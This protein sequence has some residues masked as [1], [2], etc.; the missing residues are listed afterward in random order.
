MDRR[1]TMP[2][3]DQTLAQFLIPP[4]W[5]KRLLR[6]CKQ[7][8]LLVFLSC[9]VDAKLRSLTPVKRIPMKAFPGIFAAS[10]LIAAV[11]MTSLPAQEAGGASITMAGGGATFASFSGSLSFAGAGA[12]SLTI[13]SYNY[14]TNPVRISTLTNYA[15]VLPQSLYPALF[16]S[17]TTISGGTLSS[18]GT[19]TTGGTIGL[20]LG[21]TLSVLPYGGTLSLGSTSLGT[22]TLTGANTYTG[23]TTISAGTLQIGNGNIGSLSSGGAVVLSSSGTLALNL[24]SGATFGTTVLSGTSPIIGGTG[25]LTLGGSLPYTGAT[26][27]NGGSLTLNLNGE[28]Y[29][30]GATTAVTVGTLEIG[31]GATISA[32]ITKTG[33]GTLVLTSPNTFTGT[34][35]AGTLTVNAN[36]QALTSSGNGII[37]VQGV[38]EPSA[39]ALL[40]LGV[41]LPLWRARRRLTRE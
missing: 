23:A 24:A 12:S 30:G 27:T 33:T 28:P 19:L 39:A 2:V 4:D 20:T 13:N 40:A 29:T 6:L 26:L 15:P 16:G 7:P 21:G 5:A 8:N 34:L 17:S 41:A 11:S 38:P 31:T 25:T 32:G 14:L 3:G 22:V 10:L 35:T 37:Q 1:E 18:G 9:V 36:T